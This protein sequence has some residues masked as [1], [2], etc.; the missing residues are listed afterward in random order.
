MVLISGISLVIRVCNPVLIKT[1]TTFCGLNKFHTFFTPGAYSFCLFNIF[2]C[3]IE[4]V[5]KRQFC[6]EKAICSK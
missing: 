1:M 4:E 5:Y 2:D 3:V 6:I